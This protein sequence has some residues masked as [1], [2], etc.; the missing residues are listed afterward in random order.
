MLILNRTNTGV[1]VDLKEVNDATRD[2]F[3]DAI[4]SLNPGGGTCLG[5]GM[6]RGMDVSF[7]MMF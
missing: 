6:M 1:P 4:K 3:V 5:N 7:Q 2:E